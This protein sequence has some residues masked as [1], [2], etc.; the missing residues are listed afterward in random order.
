MLNVGIRGR[1]KEIHKI[2]ELARS[3]S[4]ARLNLLYSVTSAENRSPSSYRAQEGTQSIR[5]VG[6]RVVD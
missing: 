2:L 6:L 4:Y 5:V 1:E 3:R